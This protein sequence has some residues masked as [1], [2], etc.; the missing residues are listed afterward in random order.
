M[1]KTSSAYDAPA[2]AVAMMVD[3]IVHDR[4]RILPCVA[5]LDGEY[6]QSGICMGV[7]VVLGE[8]GIERVIELPLTDEEAAEFR[9]SADNVRADIAR[10]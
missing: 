1:R 6:G 2:A 7:P 5:M 8:D 4:K 10:L 9:R 3:A